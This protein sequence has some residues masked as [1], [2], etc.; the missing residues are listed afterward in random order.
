MVSMFSK[1]VEPFDFV[2]ENEQP[3]LVIE[4]QIS[5]TSF[6]ES[7]DYPSDGRYFE[8]ILRRTS[9]VTNIRDEVVTNAT[10]ILEDDA[11]S[12]WNYIESPIGSGHY[13]LFNDEFKA[14]VR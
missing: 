12:E 6:N 10:V 13:F 14:F 9:S 5:N 8:V 1:C 7:R 4:A 11:G 2:I 3:S